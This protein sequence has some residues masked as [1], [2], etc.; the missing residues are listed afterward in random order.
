MGL[1]ARHRIDIGAADLGFAARA[2]LRPADRPDLASAVE[3]LWSEGGDAL[4]CL[5]ARS[6]FDLVLSALAL[7]H[8]GEVLLSAVTV[9]DMAAIIR[10]HGL[11]PVPVDLD[12]A[13]LSPRA[14]LL[15]RL[16]TGRSVAVL[17]AHLFGGWFDIRPVVD[18]CA[19]H[20]LPL[21]EDC[22]QSFVGRGETGSPSALASFFSFGPIKTST[23]LGGG[24]VRVRE[25]EVL[26][27]MRVLHR[28]W[29][30]QSRSAFGR[31]VARIGALT[32]LQRPLPYRLV[33][34]AASAGARTLDDVVAGSA[35]S[36]PGGEAFRR[37]P[38]APLLALL[39]RRLEADD[40]E[41]LRARSARGERVARALEAAYDLPGHS[42]PR[43]THWL[44]P[45]VA[46]DPQ[47]L[48]ADLRAEGFDASRGTSAL[49]AVPA[50]PGR[51]EAEPVAAR[52]ML[53]RAVFL[54][55]YPELPDRDLR[56]LLQAT[57]RSHWAT[58]TSRPAAT[59]MS[60]GVGAAGTPRSS[61]AVLPP[62]G[63]D[64]GSVS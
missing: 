3:R 62:P 42:R 48:V 40:G 37:Q 25:A 53:G 29:P 34:V 64:A 52:R 58:A 51:P 10:S 21:L 31:R 44:F 45:V 32:V 4:A 59:A 7:P 33:A 49:V 27:R 50:P 24:L 28:A 13:T 6:A 35:R 9:P 36:F 11:V 18:F 46:D 5:S 60:A 41:R 63:I 39:L 43:R 1:H 23:A 61:R 56:R 26:S 2:T 16:R 57:M 14:D 55:V 20:R 8:R 19:R 12:C 47:R 54:P 38:S 30:V 17:V 15:E 22:A